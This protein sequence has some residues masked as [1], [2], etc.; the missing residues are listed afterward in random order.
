MGI[1]NPFESIILNNFEVNTMKAFIALSGILLFGLAGQTLAADAVKG[2]SVFEN[3]CSGCHANGGNALMSEKSL[4]KK[5]LEENKMNTAEAII[6]QVT[7][8]KPPMPG[9]GKLG[10]ISAADIE[11]VAAYVLE[12]ANADWK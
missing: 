4:K 5:A 6:K 12:Q 11:N 7:D 1:S 8:G 9:F 2:K 10:T 3:N